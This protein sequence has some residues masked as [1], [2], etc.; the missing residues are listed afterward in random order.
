MEHN[1]LYN[2]LMNLVQSNEAFYFQDFERNGSKFRIFNYRLASYTDFLNEG[3]LE[4]RGVMF[5]VDEQG[6]FV[7]LACR[8]QP[9]FFNL[10]E[11]P[12]T[13]GLDMQHV[14]HVGLKVDGSLISTYWS[15]VDG[16][17]VLCL[18][19]KGSLFSD[20]AV[21]A[22]KWLSARPELYQELLKLTV[23]GYTVNLEWVAPDNRVVIGYLE[24]KLIVLNVREQ[25]TGKMMFTFEEL[26]EQVKPLDVAHVG[27]YW[28]DMLVVNDP[29]AFVAGVPAM[30]G[31]EGFVVVLDDGMTVKCKTEWYL[32]QHRA[33]DSINSDRRL[34]E[35]VLEEATDDLRSLFHDDPLVV[36]R[37]AE[38]EQKVDKIFNHMV[39]VVEDFY[40]ANKELSRKDYAIKGQQEV[41]P[42][43]FGLVMNKYVGKP[44]D[45]KSF[46]KSKY[47]LF[48]IKDDPEPTE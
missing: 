9:K 48:G 32:V 13:I 35:T 17:K 34:F 45:Y 41:E 27:T 10:N 5:E 33:K 36:Q 12:M 25:S 20:Q 47:K 2:K 38:M 39:R 7:R 42:L 44:T 26:A 23:A 4:A 43:Y 37:I 1:V 21:A 29:V 40:N 22:E 15:V 6:Q 16:N 11:N 8:P 30:Q 18:K 3:A 28:V 31:V 24:P 14:R 46:M 19:T